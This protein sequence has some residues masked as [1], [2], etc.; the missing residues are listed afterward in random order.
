MRNSLLLLLCLGISL[1]ATPVSYQVN[2]NTV[3]LSGTTGNVDFQYNPGPGTT[4]PSFIT[5]DFF[6]PG[7]G[8]FGAPFTV[9]GVTGILPGAVTINNSGAFNDYF[10][11]ITFT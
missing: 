1:N 3:S 6:T 2:V 10:Q 5:I 7:G 4:D 8:L 11:G 9:G